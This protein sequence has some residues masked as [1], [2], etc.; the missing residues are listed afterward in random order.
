MRLRV[1][2]GYG[3]ALDTT[4]A[5]GKLVFSIFINQ[6]TF[7]QTTIKNGKNIILPSVRVEN[8]GR[9]Y[10]LNEY[11]CHHDGSWES[12]ESYSTKTAPV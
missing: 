1:L 5:L 3:T 10:L 4:T 11:I 8:I 12:L 6:Y 2:T 9:L 7:K